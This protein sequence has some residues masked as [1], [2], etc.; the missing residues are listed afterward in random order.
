MVIDD[1]DDDTVGYY[2]LSRFLVFIRQT[3]T[4][5]APIVATMSRLKVVYSPVS[6]SLGERSM[7]RKF[8]NTST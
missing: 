3:E 1:D 2:S 6:A 5:T 8:T 4:A 7:P